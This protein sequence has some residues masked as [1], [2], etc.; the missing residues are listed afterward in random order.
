MAALIGMI[1]FLLGVLFWF[2]WT[3]SVWK[4]PQREFPKNWRIFLIEQVEFY[5]RLVPDEKRHFEYKVQEFLLNCRI[6]GISTVVDDRDRV[7]IAASAVIPIF[8]FPEWRY[9]NL[10]EVLLYPG[11]FDEDF[12]TSGKPGPIL[13]MV[14][15][16][17]MSGMM[18]LSKIALYQGFANERDR[19]HTA[20]HEF[21]HVIDTADGVADGIPS[22]LLER[23]YAIPWL[24][25]AR[26]EMERIKAG[27]S[28]IRAYGA[29]NPAEFFSVISEYFF[30]NPQTLKSKHPRI[31]ETLERVFDQKASLWSR[32]LSKHKIKRN[33][34]CPCGSGKKFKKCCGV[35]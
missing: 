18:I 23:Q 25:L 17:Y 10:R 2:L 33:S 5:N 16:G 15:T 22:V 11:A 6:T 29:T 20:I 21:I 9:T 13:G 1:V 12:R 24:D 27:S 3:T 4:K 28:D 34:P 26:Q 19:S 30:E 32:C 35:V 8:A 7:L 14:G 31:Y